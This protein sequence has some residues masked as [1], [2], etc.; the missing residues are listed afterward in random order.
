MPDGG[1]E[2]ADPEQVFLNVEPRRS[3]SQDGLGEV[4]EEQQEDE[5]AWREWAK[6]YSKHGKGF[7]PSKLLPPLTWFPAYARTVLGRAHEE[8]LAQAGGLPYSLKGDCIAGL[9]VGFMLVPQSIAFAMLAGLP[10][11]TGLYA[12]FGPLLIYALMG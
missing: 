4:E 12:S 2:A 3:S 1:G 5:E 10:V 7:H 6:Y 8:D 11:Q 9:T